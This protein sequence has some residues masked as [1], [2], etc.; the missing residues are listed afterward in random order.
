MERGEREEGRQEEKAGGDKS[1]AVSEIQAQAM[2]RHWTE[3]CIVY[4]GS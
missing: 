1:W 4:A 3:P 2:H